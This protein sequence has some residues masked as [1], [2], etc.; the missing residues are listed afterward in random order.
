MCASIHLRWLECLSE[1]VLEF[2][3]RIYGEYAHNW[4]SNGTI[5]PYIL[6]FKEWEKVEKLEIY[7]CR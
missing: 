4:Y 6:Q 5:C 2:A 7:I 3:F 1:L